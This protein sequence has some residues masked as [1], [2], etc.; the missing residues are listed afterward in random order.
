MGLLHHLG[1]YGYQLWHDTVLHKVEDALVI[2]VFLRRKKARVTHGIPV[3]LL[4]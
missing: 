3:L 4:G 2:V 1:G